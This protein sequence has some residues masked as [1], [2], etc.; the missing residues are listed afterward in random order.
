MPRKWSIEIALFLGLCL[1][2]VAS[3][4]F[5]RGVRGLPLLPLNEKLSGENAEGSWEEH[6][7]EAIFGSGAPLPGKGG[8]IVETE[9]GV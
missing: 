8:T 7:G 4:H 5:L 3:S 2:M 1:A 6:Y 9:G